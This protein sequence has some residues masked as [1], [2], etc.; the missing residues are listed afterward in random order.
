MVSNKDFSD[1]NR[2]NMPVS[3]ELSPWLR[4][5]MNKLIQPLAQQPSAYRLFR[6]SEMRDNR[7]LGES[8]LSLSRQVLG[9][10][11]LAFRWLQPL[12]VDRFTHLLNRS[13]PVI[14]T[15]WQ[16]MDLFSERKQ[17][18]QEEMTQI[19]DEN[20][21][22]YYSPNDKRVSK[23]YHSLADF[24]ARLAS[25]GN[26]SQSRPHPESYSSKD[27]R[28]SSLY[29]SLADFEAALASQGTVIPSQTRQDTGP[30]KDARVSNQYRS[31]AD[32][33]DRL[34]S[35]GNVN[36]SQLQSNA[37]Q[38]SKK[39]NISNGNP[40]VRR[41][42]SSISENRVEELEVPGRIEDATQKERTIERKPEIKQEPHINILTKP[43][44]GLS[45]ANKEETVFDSAQN[46]I[47]GSE[48][49]LS[50]IE[51]TEA[52]RKIESQVREYSPSASQIHAQPDIENHRAVKEVIMPAVEENSLSPASS[53]EYSRLPEKKN[54]L[55]QTVPIIGS[56]SNRESII[57][58]APGNTK[59]N[60]IPVPSKYPEAGSGM[61]SETRKT[62]V[63]RAVKKTDKP[64]TMK[65]S[66]AS[67]RNTERREKN[68]LK[69]AAIHNIESGSKI[70][71]RKKEIHTENHPGQ[72]IRGITGTVEPIG[73]ISPEAGVF[74]AVESTKV[75]NQ[76][77]DTSLKSEVNQRPTGS[78]IKSENMGKQELDSQTTTVQASMPLEIPPLVEYQAAQSSVE[79][80]INAAGSS[81][82]SSDA[83]QLA[84]S[85]ETVS[86]EKNNSIH[87]NR[88]SPRSTNINNTVHSPVQPD[89][90]KS[91]SLSLNRKSEE[92]I[93][94]PSNVYGS[95]ET[96]KR[97]E[98]GPSISNGPAFDNNARQP[99]SRTIF[100]SNEK[101]ELVRS[102]ETEHSTVQRIN[103][104]SSPESIV[105][106]VT[107]NN[108]PGVRGIQRPAD[109]K[110][111]S[112]KTLP[113]SLS[114]PG[115]TSHAIPIRETLSE[116]S[117]NSISL[118]SQ[119][120]A[121]QKN[122]KVVHNPE[123]DA[124][125]PEP[126]KMD[127]IAAG[128]DN[129][130]PVFPGDLIAAP[131]IPVNRVHRFPVIDTQSSNENFLPLSLRKAV[132]KNPPSLTGVYRRTVK[133]PQDM[134]ESFDLNQSAATGNHAAPVSGYPAGVQRSDN[135][136]RSGNDAY[137]IPSLPGYDPGLYQ[138]IQADGNRRSGLSMQRNFNQVAPLNRFNSVMG[139]GISPGSN[140]RNSERNYFSGPLPVNMPLAAPA[141]PKVDTGVESGDKVFRSTS[142][143]GVQM[144][145]TDREPVSMSQTMLQRSLSG[146]ENSST[147]SVQ[148]PSSPALENGNA[149]DNG[150]GLKKLAR[151]LYPLL[152]PYI[153]R[154][155]IVD[156]ERLPL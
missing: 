36:S 39:E 13:T 11:Q 132:G 46:E 12:L 109:I 111:S 19:P 5:R 145:K 138:N 105:K 83:P 112:G 153:K 59:T 91:S 114:K 118:S 42:R 126:S 71:L 136:F 77:R 120:E 72:N 151:E 7:H 143:S 30:S 38:V 82:R 135:E 128:Q 50:S 123:I 116:T 21:S 94:Y 40:Q 144:A 25:Q 150:P 125:E 149:S 127:S 49:G 130:P 75:P 45:R 9:R 23:S 76:L 67:A 34:A 141:R 6:L 37:K 81:D 17:I 79:Q 142:D 117:E 115:L 28:V 100:G 26:V 54:I 121:R 96:E 108:Q 74:S 106:S 92:S 93:V 48:E 104:S 129:E 52:E 68:N 148:P 134:P 95:L 47:A 1:E 61:T 57:E 152:Y 103:R 87:F 80:K 8:N 154:M 140:R 18:T 35:Q 113:L 15:A 85:I 90:K 122:M 101:P 44:P 14:S 98:N 29:R 27:A 137:K 156:R 43:E 88:S 24:E 53:S 147:S 89:D 51:E 119:P 16:D 3:G 107:G 131:S 84:R 56:Q 32:F 99:I 60:N 73:N 22:R 20:L 62:P 2:K 78:D 58:P 4:M 31:L 97:I 124:A 65:R 133:G 86:P 155:I 64:L 33:E 10:R 66:T 70:S 41:V 139:A 146:N 69:D 55:D 102:P 63:R 110:V